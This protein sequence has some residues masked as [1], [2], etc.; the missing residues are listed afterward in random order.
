MKVLQFID[1]LRYIWSNV[2]VELVPHCI[3]CVFLLAFIHWNPER[4]MRSQNSGVPP[5]IRTCA[6]K[7]N[8]LDTTMLTMI[9]EVNSVRK[10]R[11]KGKERKP[12]ISDL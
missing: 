6:Y 1:S 4:T 3:C 10:E 8:K 5:L 7:L 9:D 2:T 12:G 11:V